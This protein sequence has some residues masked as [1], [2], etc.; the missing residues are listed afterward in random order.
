MMS[1]FSLYALLRHIDYGQLILFSECLVTL[2]L[3]LVILALIY[4]TL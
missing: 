2:L 4:N 1:L 3:I